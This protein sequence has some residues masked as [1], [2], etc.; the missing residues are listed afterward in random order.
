MRFFTGE[1]KTIS[2]DQVYGFIQYP[3]TDLINIGGSIIVCVSDKSVAFVPTI[4]Y[5]L[6]ENVDLMLIG[7]FYVGDEGKTFSSSLGNG[8]FFRATVYF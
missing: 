4:N 2:Q 8:G 6:F 3:L 7:N 5:S 1:T